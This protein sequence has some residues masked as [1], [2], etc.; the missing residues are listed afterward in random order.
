MTVIKEGDRDKAKSLDL[1]T[2]KFKC[3]FCGC[4]FEANKDKYTFGQLY[5][6]IGYFCKCPCCGDTAEAVNSFR[7]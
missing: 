7:L 5:D 4:E 3:D 1:K 2:L 6:I